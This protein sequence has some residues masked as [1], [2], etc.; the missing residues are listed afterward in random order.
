MQQLATNGTLSNDIHFENNIICAWHLS[1][2]VMYIG[3]F[4]N[5]K[6]MDYNMKFYQHVTHKINLLIS[7]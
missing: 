3:H 2:W 1:V 6:C 5:R 4:Y 7:W